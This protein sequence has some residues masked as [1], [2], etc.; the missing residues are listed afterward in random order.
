MSA[1]L[2]RSTHPSLSLGSTGEYWVSPI[3]FTEHHVYGINEYGTTLLGNPAWVFFPADGGYASEV[4]YNTG[5]P[6]LGH[7]LGQ[8]TTPITLQM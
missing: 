8:H 2:G 1:Q 4:G 5:V 6:Q 7:P 3:T